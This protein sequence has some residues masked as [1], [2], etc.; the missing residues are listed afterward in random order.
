MNLPAIISN[1]YCFH[2]HSK[3][4]I[5]VGLLKKRLHCSDDTNLDQDLQTS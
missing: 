4:Y 1:D 3:K 5:N 2:K